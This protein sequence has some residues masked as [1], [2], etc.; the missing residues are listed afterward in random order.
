MNPVRRKVIGVI[1]QIA[2]CNVCHKR[3]E[4]HK[5][6]TANARRHTQKTGHTTS[7]ETGTA[8]DYEVVS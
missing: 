4:W 2:W 5:T 3:W 8:H 6:A 1:H 7:V